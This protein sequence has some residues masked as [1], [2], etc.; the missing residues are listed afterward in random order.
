MSVMNHKSL[1]A[2]HGIKSL[3]NLLKNIMWQTGGSWIHYLDEAM[4]TYNFFLMP[5]LDGLSPFEL[6]YG[7]QAKI[8][9]DLEL[10]PKVPIQITYCVYIC[11]F[12]ALVCRCATTLL[13]ISSQFKGIFY[14]TLTNF[15]CPGTH[16]YW[17]TD[18]TQPA[19]YFKSI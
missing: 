19:K 3:S 7:C 14:G 5:N 16:E 2:E 13:S 8:I 17:K 15:N 9:P 18:S 11:D 1:L 12:Y 10:T 4:L 6:V